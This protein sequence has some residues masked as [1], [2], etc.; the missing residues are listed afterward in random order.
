MNI[1]WIEKYRV[2]KLSEIL[3]QNEAISILT[4]I[5]ETGE[6]P[7]LLLYGGS[8]VGKTSS[9][10]ALCNQ[11]YGPKRIN[12]RVIELNASDERGIGVVR[13]KIIQFAKLTIGTKDPNYLCPPYKIIILDE[14]DAM[15][16]EAQSAL[17]KVMEDTSHITRFVFICN[18][19]NQI[20]DP[21]N[22]RC[23]C[24]KFKQI[25]F[26]QINIKLNDISKLENINI[27]KNG[28]NCISTISCGDLRKALL[29]LQNV[30]YY[31]SMHDSKN[32][33]EKNI[34]DMNKWITK[35]TIKKYFNLIKKNSDI[36][37]IMEISNHII[38]EGYVFNSILRKIIEHVL[39]LNISDIKKA[40]ILFNV[41]TIEK[42]I[43]DRSNEYIQLLNLFFNI[44]KIF[45]E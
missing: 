23:V 30:K 39:E 29:I 22:S 18:Y 43:I 42:L 9:V 13:H 6:M 5:A 3:S 24:I 32:V 36:K 12:E 44:N 26:E 1:S 37:T 35:K 33:T 2:K 7:H 14:A 28:I 20:I 11:L 27:D 15:T 31:Y 41:G 38:N 8:G 19:I 4:N 10:L 34:Y 21:I 17:R 45:N 25:D 16:K 40:Q